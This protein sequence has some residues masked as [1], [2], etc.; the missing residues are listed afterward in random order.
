M[1]LYWFC[2]LGNYVAVVDNLNGIIIFAELKIYSRCLNYIEDSDI[3]VQD[4]SNDILRELRH[5]ARELF[6]SGRIGMAYL[7]GSRVRGEAKEYSD[8]DVL[9]ILNDSVSRDKMFERFAF[10]FA[11]IGWRYGADINPI[12]FTASEWES[13]SNTFFY[14]NIINE[15]VSL[16][17]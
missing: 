13:Q 17:A 7:Y 1:G 14:Q 9:I 10:P 3:A 6:S 15:L 5:V 11:E 12:Y 2:W 8:W 16:G 4:K